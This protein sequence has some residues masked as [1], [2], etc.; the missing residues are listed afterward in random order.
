MANRRSPLVGVAL[1]AVAVEL[2]L[3]LSLRER[4]RGNG[5]APRGPLGQ[6]SVHRLNEIRRRGHRKLL[7]EER[8]DARRLHVRHL[9]SERSEGGLCCSVGTRACGRLVT[10]ALEVALAGAAVCG[11]KDE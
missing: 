3:A 2:P 4:R 11:S 6:H 7:G 8:G 9:R 10:R 5:V 1:A